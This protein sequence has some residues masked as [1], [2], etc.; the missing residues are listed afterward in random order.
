MTRRNKIAN[1]FSP[2][3]VCEGGAQLDCKPAMSKHQLKKERKQQQRRG[4]SKR[5][6]HTNTELSSSKSGEPTIMEE[7]K[8]GIN[9]SIIIIRKTILVL[10]II[11]CF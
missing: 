2:T 5:S 8:K 10:I 7:D 9:Y 4:R 11:L 1:S 6:N 3:I